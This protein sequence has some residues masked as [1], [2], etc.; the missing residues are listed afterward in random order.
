MGERV[1]FPRSRP[2]LPLDP[3]CYRPAPRSGVSGWETDNEAR[4]ARMELAR[5]MGPILIPFGSFH[6]FYGKLMTRTKS[7]KSLWH[8]VRN[9]D[10]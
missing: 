9:L 2:A 1:S 3:C 8:R 7:L 5:L 6:P 10:R 4:Q